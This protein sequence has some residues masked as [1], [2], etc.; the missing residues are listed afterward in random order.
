M[1]F[2]PDDRQRAVVEAVEAALDGPGDGGPERRWT[3]LGK[4]GIPA[5]AMPTWLGGDG[6]GT[7]EVAAVLTEI[8]RR[9]E[10]LP[11]LATLA[12]G[13]LPVVRWGSREQQRD[14]LTGV[15][16]GS[17]VLTAG[18][19]EPSEP[20]PTAPRTTITRGRAVTGKKLGVPYAAQAYRILTPVSLDAG[21]VGVALVDPRATGV[22]LVRTPTCGSAPEYSLQLDGAPATGLLDAAAVE[23]L[24][25]HVVAAACAAGDGLLAGAL[26]LTSAHVGS[27]EQ[28]G[29]PLAAF[30]A[31][32]QQIADVYVASRTLHLATVSACWRLGA[33]LD[34]TGDL[35][36]AAYWLAGEALPALR[37]CHHLHG[38]LGLD[39]AYPLHR[40]SA[41]ARDLVR[42]LGGTEACLERLG[43]RHAHRAV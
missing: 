1:R 28:F 31:V 2:A 11:A 43:S 39:V 16:T 12:L 42:S 34:A 23:D 3:A 17:T 32:A 22:T 29:R 41:L 13:V 24:Y 35:D 30:Q 26:A 19:R 20:M 14:L 6:L 8:G 4:A 40:Y 10:A 27:R 18:W 37:T 21:G 7:A 36:V 33:G 5:L 15:P 38:G 25:R 9:A